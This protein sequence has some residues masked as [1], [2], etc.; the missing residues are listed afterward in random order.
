M[1]FREAQA[2]SRYASG[3]WYWDGHCLKWEYF[4]REEYLRAL[5]EHHRMW[6]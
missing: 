5:I 6:V 2:M 1:A 3:Q 4:T